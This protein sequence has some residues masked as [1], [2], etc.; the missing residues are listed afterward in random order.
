MSAVKKQAVCVFLR[1]EHGHILAASRR[2]DHTDFGLPGGKVDEGETLKQAAV[3]ELH[4]ETGYHI[5]FLS[6]IFEHD[7][8]PGYHTTT[9]TGHLYGKR[10]AVDESEGVVRWVT[11]EELL[12]G[13]FGDYNRRLL[14]H[15][16]EA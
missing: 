13:T 12:A 16:N 5:S 4:E 3:R 1:N 7:C 2:D 8:H 6:V 10:D 14:K 11:E 15:I 9:F